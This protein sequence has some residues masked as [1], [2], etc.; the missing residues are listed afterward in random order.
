MQRIL[1][2]SERL[3]SHMAKIHESHM[4]LEQEL[5]TQA[6]NNWKIDKHM[7]SLK[8]DLMQLH[9]IQ[10][11]RTWHVGK[12]NRSQAEEMLNGRWEGTFLI[13]ESSQRD[14]Y[15][16]SVVV[17][18][19][20]QHCVT[21]PTATGLGFVEPYSL[22]GSLKK[23][24]LHYQHTS[25]VQHND[26]LTLT[27]DGTFLIRESSQQGCYACSVVVDSDAVSSTT[28]PLAWVLRSPTTCTG[29]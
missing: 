13:R 9:E 4:K 14:C 24:V 11:E 10:L 20:T 12:I 8:P 21:Y 7:N 23:L 29:L 28:W 18:S 2:N 1:L 16:C 25:L 19:D 26:A 5:R 15:A 17:D 3:K 22:Y 6:L 27:L